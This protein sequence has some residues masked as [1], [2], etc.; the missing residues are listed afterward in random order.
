MDAERK[1][2]FAN[3]QIAYLGIQFVKTEQ[4]LNGAGKYMPTKFSQRREIS[5]YAK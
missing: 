5:G 2:Q 4:A 1:S 3:Q